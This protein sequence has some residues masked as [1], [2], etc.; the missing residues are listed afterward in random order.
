MSAGMQD[1]DSTT[2][3]VEGDGT[4]VAI[5]HDELDAKSVMDRVRSP[6]CGAIVLFAGES[7]PCLPTFHF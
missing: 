6:K 1:A 4:F 7:V 3:Q 2:Q 5:T